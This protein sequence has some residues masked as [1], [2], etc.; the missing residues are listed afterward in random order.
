MSVTVDSS[1]VISEEI[2]RDNKKRLIFTHSVSDGS[3]LGPFIEHR[4][5]D[6]NQEAINSFLSASRASYEASLN[7]ETPTPE[8]DF[9]EMIL[10]QEDDFIKE[11]LEITDLK[12]QALK[13]K[14]GDIK[15]P[16]KEVIK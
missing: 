11:T 9:L 12:L 3:T 13:G 8:E 10:S 7:Q 15:D 2:V 6:D 1:N 16:I 4:N 5:E 14:L